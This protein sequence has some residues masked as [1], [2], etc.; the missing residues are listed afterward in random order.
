MLIGLPGQVL[1]HSSTHIHG[2]TSQVHFPVRYWRQGRSS[3]PL[4]ATSKSRVQYVA[5]CNF[6]SDIQWPIDGGHP[7][8]NSRGMDEAS[9]IAQAGCSRSAAAGRQQII[10]TSPTVARGISS[11]HM[12]TCQWSLRERMCAGCLCPIIPKTSATVSPLTWL[13]FCASVCAGALQ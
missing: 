12:E 4:R 13:T 5:V 11:V 7:D 2:S 9:H 6:M 3:E 1:H 8:G 10:Q